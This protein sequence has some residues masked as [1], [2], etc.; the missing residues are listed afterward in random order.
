MEFNVDHTIPLWGLIC[1][2]SAGIYFV[3]QIKST[4]M[5]I[6]KRVEHTEDALDKIEEKFTII[7]K[8]IK[9]LLIEIRTKK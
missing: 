2:I 3:W 6:D 4:L 7:E 8:D 9:D 5:L 1:A